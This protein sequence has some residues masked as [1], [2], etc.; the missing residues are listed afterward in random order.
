MRTGASKSLALA[1]GIGSTVP[2]LAQ[3][4]E[5]VDL[6]RDGFVSREEVV[7]HSE[8][9]FDEMAEGGEMTLGQFVAANAA[10]E[11]DMTEEE[12]EAAADP[13][14]ALDE[15]DADQSGTVSREEWMRWRLE[16]FDEAAGGPAQ[17]GVEAREG[18]GGVELG[19]YETL[20]SRGMAG[21]EGGGAPL[22]EDEVVDPEEVADPAG[23]E[24]S[25]GSAEGSEG[26]E[27]DE[28]SQG[29]SGR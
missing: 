7:A 22:V 2:V 4:P 5:S 10:T 12:A 24:E 15:A 3:E 20:Y 27:P 6:D 21:V 14:T 19:L 23:G 9:L 29:D 17:G 25:E 8:R 13:A 16:Q 1:L 11:A 28:T 26:G 18:E